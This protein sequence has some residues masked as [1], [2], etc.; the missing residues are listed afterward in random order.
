M[1]CVRVAKREVNFDSAKIVGDKRL[2]KKIKQWN[3]V[4]IFY[5]IN[6]GVTK[7]LSQISLNGQKEFGEKMYQ[8]YEDETFKI[9]KSKKSGRQGSTYFGLNRNTTL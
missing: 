6:D 3:R 7:S 1:V 9:G 4:V 5:G 2:K 8:G